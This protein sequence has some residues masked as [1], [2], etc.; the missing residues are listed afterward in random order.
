[1]SNNEAGT[2]ADRTSRGHLSINATGNCCGAGGRSWPVSTF[3]AAQRYVRCRGQTG[4][5]TDDLNPTLLTLSGHSAGCR[6]AQSFARQ[7]HC[8]WA[9]PKFTA[10]VCPDLRYIAAEVECLDRHVVMSAV[11]DFR[12]GA[13]CFRGTNRH[14]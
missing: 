2:L 3:A 1:M 12:A 4:L 14:P 5:F 7:V 11:E 9:E 8:D 6:C 10:A 13:H